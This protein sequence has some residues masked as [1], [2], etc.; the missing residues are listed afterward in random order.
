MKLLAETLHE[1]HDP[2][3]FRLSPPRHPSGSSLSG[4]EDS[5][6]LGAVSVVDGSRTAM[7]TG[8][9]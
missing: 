1:K 4:I 8:G 2:H 9:S 5:T 7:N 6:L 3:W